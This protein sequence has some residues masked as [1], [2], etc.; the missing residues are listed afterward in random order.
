[1]QQPLLLFVLLPC[2]SLQTSTLLLSF[3]ILEKGLLDCILDFQ[4]W[5]ETNFFANFVSLLQISLFC[6]LSRFGCIKH[7]ILDIDRNIADCFCGFPL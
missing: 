4:E 1:V 2:L 6:P 7:Q 5:S 3:L